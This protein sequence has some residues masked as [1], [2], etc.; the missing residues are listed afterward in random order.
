M[1]TTPPLDANLA[2]EGCYR[3]CVDDDA[4]LLAD[5]FGLGDPLRAQPQHVEG[6][7]QV[8]VHHLAERVQRE[9]AVLT[10]HPDG[11]T[12]AGA[13]DHDAQRAKRFGDIQG[14]GHRRLVGDVGRRETRT[15]AEFADHLLAFEVEHNHLRAG[16]EQALGGGQAQP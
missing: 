15:I 10:Q 9:N 1:P 3:R 2:V 11:V 5:Q 13:V 16:I 4:A 6:A 7:D 12:G 14:R 8:D